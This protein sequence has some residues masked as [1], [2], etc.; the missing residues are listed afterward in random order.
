MTEHTMQI[1]FLMYQYFFKHKPGDIC[2]YAM[3]P[4]CHHSLI[5]Q[6]SGPP[7]LDPLHRTPRVHLFAWSWNPPQVVPTCSF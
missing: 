3:K 4:V 5:P 6:W 2:E 1:S 7:L